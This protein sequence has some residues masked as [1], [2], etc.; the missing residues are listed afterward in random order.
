MAKRRSGANRSTTRSNIAGGG[1]KTTGTSGGSTARAGG[2][3]TYA[4]QQYSEGAII[5]Q[6]GVQQRCVNGKWQIVDPAHRGRG[7]LPSNG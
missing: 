5:D 4:G 7:G 2:D 3:C 1:D 6:G